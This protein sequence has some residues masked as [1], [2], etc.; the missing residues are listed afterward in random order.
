VEAIPND[1]YCPPHCAMELRGVSLPRA[2]STHPKRID[3]NTPKCAGALWHSRGRQCGRL[4]PQ[5]GGTTGEGISAQ[6]VGIVGRLAAMAS[7]GHS[8]M[9]R[10]PSPSQVCCCNPSTPQQLLPHNMDLVLI[11][12]DSSGNFSGPTAPPPCKHQHTEH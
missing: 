1:R 2:V 3:Q 5:V 10:T 7:L 4:Q 11:L 9:S 12:I 6:H 8:P